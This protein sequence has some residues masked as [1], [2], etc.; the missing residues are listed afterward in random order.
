MSGSLA[1]VGKSLEQ[2]S[3]LLG[4]EKKDTLNLLLAFGLCGRKPL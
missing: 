1:C 3:K 2:N 4:L